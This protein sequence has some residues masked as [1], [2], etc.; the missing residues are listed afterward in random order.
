MTLVLSI[1]LSVLGLDR[2]LTANGINYQ[3]LLGFSLIVGF[4]G[5]IFS[6]LISK[7]MAKWSTG[8]RVIDG[9]ENST[10]YS[11]QNTVRQ[12]LFLPGAPTVIDCEV[13]S[14]DV[15]QCPELR[16]EGVDHF[17]RAGREREETD[18]PDFALLLS[19]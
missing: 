5:S 8:A 14:F 7:P 19:E 2:F 16:A 11:I 13:A 10:D 15:S 1:V 4:G 18:P 12:A 9:S 6:L 3:L 17:V